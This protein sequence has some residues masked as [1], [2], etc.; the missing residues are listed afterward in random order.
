MARRRDQKRAVRG[1]HGARAV[2]D[3]GSLGRKDRERSRVRA[4]ERVSCGSEPW[5][6]WAFELGGPPLLHAAAANNAM[7]MISF[8]HMEFAPCL[9]LGSSRSFGTTPG[10]ARGFPGPKGA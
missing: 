1:R 3:D 8:S 9:V 4:E 2:E 5:N 7:A 10:G 6:A